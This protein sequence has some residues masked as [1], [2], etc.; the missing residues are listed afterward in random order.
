MTDQTMQF[1]CEHCQVDFKAST[2]SILTRDADQEFRDVGIRCPNC[3]SFY[4]AYF[5]TVELDRRRGLL[6][7]AQNIMQSRPSQQNEARWRRAKQ[8]YQASFDE[9]QKLARAARGIE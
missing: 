2:G 1:H 4:H 5:T 7:Q 8:L 3:K 6:R 9:V